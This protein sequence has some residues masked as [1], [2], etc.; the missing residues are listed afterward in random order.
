MTTTREEFNMANEL[1]TKSVDLIWDN[2]LNT[3]KAI[4]TVQEDTEKR[5]VEAFSTQKATLDQALNSYK[6]VEEK[7]NQ[8]IKDWQKQVT[9]SFEAVTTPAQTAQ[10]SAWFDTLKQV[11]QQAQELSWRPNQAVVEYIRN[12]QNEWEKAINTTLS[13][14]KEEREK[15][16]ANI[17]ELTSKLKENHKTLLD[18]VPT[19]PQVPFVR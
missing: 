10:F 7:S 14:Q 2:W 18:S 3:V 19:L 17:E 13:Q 1:L 6:V 9:S 16:L 8:A 5:A 11:T 4:N 12:A 15:A